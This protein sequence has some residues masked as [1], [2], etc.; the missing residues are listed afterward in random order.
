MVIVFLKTDDE[1]SFYE[2]K[3]FNK[4]IDFFF[5]S[6]ENYIANKGKKVK[7]SFSYVETK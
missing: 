4:D 2:L 6:F 1:T 5:L 3:I 7:S